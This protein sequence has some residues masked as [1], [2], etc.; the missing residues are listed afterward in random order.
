[1]DRKAASPGAEPST[2]Q[3]T[4]YVLRHKQVSLH[5]ETIYQIVY[6]DKAEGGDLYKYL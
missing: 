2:Q 5:H 4:D 3:V 1:M 6:A